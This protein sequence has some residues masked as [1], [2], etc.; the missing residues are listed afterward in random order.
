MAARI[1]LL[2]T[3]IVAA[4]VYFAWRPSVFNPAAPVFSALFLAVE[5][6]G[7]VSGLIYLLSVLRFSSRQSPVAPPGLSV[8]VFIPT[9]NE[10]VEIVRRTAIASL[11]IAYPHET[12]VLDD[13]NRP[14]MRALAAELGCHYIARSKNTDAKAG[15]LNNA[16]TEAKGDFVALFDADFSAAPGFLDRTLG[17]FSD[18]KVAFVQTPQEFY[19]FDSYQHMGSNRSHDS[20]SE[21]SLF[22][23]VIQRGRDRYNA[24]MMCGC[25]A[26]LRRKALDSIGGIATGT[27]TEDMHTSLRLHAQGW[28]SVF[29]PETLSAGIA[30]HDATSFRRQRL[31]WAQGAIQVMKKER[32]F[33]GRGGLSAFQRMAYLLHVST[34]FESLRYAFIY[35]VSAVALFYGVSPLDTPFSEWA[36]YSLPYMALGFLSFEEFS[37]G[38]GRLLRTEAY[39]LARCTDYIRA[40]FVLFGQRYIVFRVTPKIKQRGSAYAF[41][42]FI[43]IANLSALAYAAWQWIFGTPTVMGWPLVIIALWACFSASM[44]ARICF[45]TF[46][47]NRNRRSFSRFPVELPVT[48]QLAE[49][50]GRTCRAVVTELSDKGLTLRPQILGECLPSGLCRGQL[51]LCDRDVPFEV[52]LR[53]GAPGTVAAGVLSWGD[54]AARDDYEY[55]VITNRINYL[56]TFDNT[57]RKTS[58][59]P[60]VWL[61]HRARF[62]GPRVPAESK[63]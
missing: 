16:L 8:D 18:P 1:V 33:I 21:H 2:A 19:N 6:I 11:R 59:A 44:G 22:Y 5:V 46:R 50:G 49:A 10:P 60:L 30:P 15:N 36:P 53:P 12:W 26:V 9:Y 34:Y 25:A 37:R 62:A 32:L 4:L 58:L 27:V 29:H 28:T 61:L 39:N 7:F 35:L 42:W 51:R 48:L 45:L 3:Y 63:Q 40:L 23:R 20:W 56:A 38:Y 17:Y 31:R 47:C 14:A 52:T 57:D 54:T 41:P 13:G 55:L 43:L 24:A